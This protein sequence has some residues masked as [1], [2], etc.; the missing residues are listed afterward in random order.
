MEL[1]NKVALIVGGSSG[2]GEATARKFSSEGATCAVVASNNIRKA[3]KVAR[4]I[5]RNSKGYVWDITKPGQVKSLVEKV[6]I[7][8]KK[9]NVLLFYKNGVQILPQIFSRIS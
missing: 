9:I 8:H 3:N 2:L 6:L 4:E 7:N 5:K 1:R